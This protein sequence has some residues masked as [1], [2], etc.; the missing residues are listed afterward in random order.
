M[1][2]ERSLKAWHWVAMHD[3][4]RLFSNIPLLYTSVICGN[5]SAVTLNA[6]VQPDAFHASSAAEMVEHMEL[7]Q[8]KRQ[9]E[10]L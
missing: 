1:L 8:S 7:Q 2:L 5:A 6:W 3:L 9:S 10:I 4:S